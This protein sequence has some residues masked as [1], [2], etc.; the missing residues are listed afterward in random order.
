MAKQTPQPRCRYSEAAPSRRHAAPE[1]DCPADSRR[2][3]FERTRSAE[4]WLRGA[5]PGGAGR[6]GVARGW[7]TPASRRCEF[8]Q[9]DE[10]ATPRPPSNSKRKQRRQWVL[11]ANKKGNKKGRTIKGERKVFGEAARRR[12]ERGQD[13]EILRL[14]N[15]SSIVLDRKRPAPPAATERR[16]GHSGVTSCAASASA[17]TTSLRELPP[18]S[19]LEKTAK[20]QLFRP[21]A[22][23][24]PGGEGKA[25]DSSREIKCEARHTS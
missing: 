1:A 19:W 13:K 9:A 7:P 11:V 14:F 23:G 18:F 12:A 6:R 8:A 25:A 21:V 10:K 5:S 2:N 16:P 20:Q 3:P 22:A 24:L 17:P 15:C 4:L